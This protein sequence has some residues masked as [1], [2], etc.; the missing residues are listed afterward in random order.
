MFIGIIVRHRNIRKR[1]FK[2]NLVY[3]P[4]TTTNN[5]FDKKQ[6]K[7]QIKWFHLSYSVNVK[8]NI[9]KI[10]LSLL[11]KSFPKNVKNNVKI[12]Y[13]GM[14]NISSIITEHNKLQLQPKIT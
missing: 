1:G 11:K 12:S 7:R 8:T 9:D 6:R 2:E 10:F 14:S 4:R 13:S 5:S 3:V